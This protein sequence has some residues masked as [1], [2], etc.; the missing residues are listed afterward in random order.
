MSAFLPWRNVRRDIDEELRFHFDARIGEL[1][2]LG[3]S[4]EAAR[5][6]ALEEFGNVE[7]VRA[8]LKS[9]DDRVVA[10]QKRADIL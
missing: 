1:I 2:A 3:M 4:A 8:D 7:E 10:Q 9:I 6:K 5:A